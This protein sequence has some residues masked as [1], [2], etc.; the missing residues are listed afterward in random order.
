VAKRVLF[1]NSNKL[2]NLELVPEWP[3][4]RRRMSESEYMEEGEDDDDDQS[5]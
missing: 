5:M 4:K 3:I 1:E 2:Y